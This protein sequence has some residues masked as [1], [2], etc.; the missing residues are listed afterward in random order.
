LHKPYKET[1]AAQRFELSARLSG[2][3][4]IGRI[5]RLQ[6]NINTGKVAPSIGLS[7]AMKTVN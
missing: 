5:S 3:F 2:S 1:Q 7:L 6:Q 4:T